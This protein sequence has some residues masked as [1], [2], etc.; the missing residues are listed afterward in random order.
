MFLHSR[1]FSQYCRGDTSGQ[2]SPPCLPQTWDSWLVTSHDEILNPQLSPCG[3]GVTIKSGLDTADPTAK[4]TLLQ[5][6]H[7]AHTHQPPQAGNP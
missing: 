1:I 3:R 2:A 7:L 5:D 6:I 4:L